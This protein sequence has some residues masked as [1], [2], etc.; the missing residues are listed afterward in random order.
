MPRAGAKTLSPI[1]G[2]HQFPAGHH[3]EWLCPH[4][5]RAATKDCAVP[6]GGG[7]GPQA[8]RRPKANH[9]P[10]R[11]GMCPGPLAGLGSVCLAF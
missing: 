7:Q 8:P 3:R 9:S 2:C 5:G 4:F 6:T 1:P 11:T 10:L